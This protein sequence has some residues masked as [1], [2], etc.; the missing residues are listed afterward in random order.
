MPRTIALAALLLFVSACTE[1]TEPP[2][3]PVERPMELM[4]KPLVGAQPELGW[5]PVGALTVYYPGYGYGGSFCSG[6]LIAPDWVLTAAHC[7]KDHDGFQIYPDVVEFYLG[8]D[9]R[10][11]YGAK[12]LEGTFHKADVFFPHPNYSSYTGA[13]DIGL[14]HLKSPVQGVEPV[15]HSYTAM[16][17]SF[18]GE[19]C[20][21][22]GFGVDDGIEQTGGGLKRSGTMEIVQIQ[23]MGYVSEYGGTGVCFGDSGGPGLFEVGGAWKVIGV[24]STVGNQY[25][26]PCMGY[27]HQVRVDKYASWIADK[28]GSPLPSCQEDPSIC[29]CTEACEADGSC[30]NSVCQYMDCQ[31]AYNCMVG[32]GYDQDCADECYAQ[33]LPE[34]KMQIQMMQQCF[35]TEC[36][37]LG[38]DAFQECAYDKCGDEITTCFPMQTGEQTCEEAYDCMNECG[39]DQQCQTECYY[40]GTAGA[41]QQLSDMFAC[42]KDECSWAQTTEV[43]QGCVWDHCAS[44]IYSCIPPSDCTLPG[45]DCEA[46]E[47]CSP[48]PGGWSECVPSNG[49][50][51]GAPCTPDLPEMEDCADGL[52]C[53]Q[54]AEG[55]FCYQ[56]CL[57]FAN[58]TE[59]EYCW[60]PVWGEYP[61]VGI[62]ICTDE[63][64]DG[65]CKADD[66]DDTD[67]DIHPDAEEL[68]DDGTDN[69]CDGVTDEGCPG[70][71]EEPDPDE[72]V[73]EGPDPA[74]D[75]TVTEDDAGGGGGL[76]GVLELK[77]TNSS[78]TAGP[79]GR[80]TAVALLLLALLALAALR[81]QPAR[82][83]KKIGAE[84]PPTSSGAAFGTDCLN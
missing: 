53:V 31:Q 17:N 55:A 72:D 40:Q 30:N 5:E 36:G 29:Y 18:V 35:E 26:D 65:V 10:P 64:K 57:S 47:A 59:D 63:D 58:C 15:P 83:I 79:T 78:C 28:I 9:A 50:Q 71:P 51:K 70:G 32:C 37:G 33:A 2:A 14:V 21:Y 8:P 1:T 76:H 48:I 12:P 80:P 44:E 4:K 68:C 11:H 75:A 13:A 60:S 49:K 82:P 61:D 45:G 6:T 39:Q 27:A 66:C 38:G 73:I 67:E 62:C 43:W 77:A 7:L 25:G 16:N 20:L 41:Q 19:N 81:R 23:N 56:F 54:G 69:D 52:V 24:N 74:G 42:F 46:N 84:A 3:A 22:V 34:A